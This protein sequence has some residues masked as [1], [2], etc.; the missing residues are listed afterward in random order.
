[1]EG[2][3]LSREGEGAQFSKRAAPRAMN[4]ENGLEPVPSKRKQRRQRAAGRGWKGVTKKRDAEL[5]RRLQQIIAE[6]DGEMGEEGQ[7]WT[8]G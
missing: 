1:M 3:R 2:E 7:G 5:E 4:L 6:T 8:E